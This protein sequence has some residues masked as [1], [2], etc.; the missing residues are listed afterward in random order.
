[1]SSPL[2]WQYTIRAGHSPPL[3]VVPVTVNQEGNRVIVDNWKD[4]VLIDPAAN[5]FGFASV[6]AKASKTPSAGP[7]T[8][9]VDYPGA[10]Q[11]NTRDS[12]SQEVRIEE[13]GP[14]RVVVYLK[15]R[16]ANTYDGRHDL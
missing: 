6:T 4:F 12:R 3:P 7:L 13:R 16:L 5:G 8:L 9:S 11:L 1:M 14:L 10:I 2:P 15:G